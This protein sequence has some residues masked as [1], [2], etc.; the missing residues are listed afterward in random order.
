M[1]NRLGGAVEPAFHAVKQIQE[2][3]DDDPVAHG[4]QLLD[5]KGLEPLEGER[6]RLAVEERPERAL[7][8]V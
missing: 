1:M 2:D 7:L 6:V 4:H 3:R 5:L 8:F